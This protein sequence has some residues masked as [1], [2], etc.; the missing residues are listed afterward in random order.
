MGQIVSAL[1]PEGSHDG[2]FF[3]ALLPR[4]IRQEA[5]QLDDLPL[6]SAI[7][8]EI[9]HVKDESNRASA[10]LTAAKKTRG[11]HLLFIHSEADART[12]RQPLRERVEPGLVKMSEY[13]NRL[14]KSGHDLPVP[15]VLIPVQATEAWILA[16]TERLSNELGMDERDIVSILQWRNP[17]RIARPKTTLNEIRQRAEASIGDRDF[18]QTLGQRVR[19]EKLE[20]LSSYRAFA[21]DLRAA[22]VSVLSGMR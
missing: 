15:V 5:I 20:L 18:F 12:A 19:I 10:I 3:G 13:S 2:N 4:V 7:G 11:R 22:L 9:V 6:I 8:P 1:Y 16:D 21:D 14:G 17:E